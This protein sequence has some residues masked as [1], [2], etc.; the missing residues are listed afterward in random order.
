MTVTR[1]RAPRGTRRTTASATAWRRSPAGSTARRG[2]SRSGRDDRVA[3]SAAGSA[4]GSGVGAVRTRLAARARARAVRG[5]AGRRRARAA[6]RST[7]RAR[8]V[9]P[10]PSRARSSGSSASARSRSATASTSP[11]GTTK[12]ETPSVDD[13]AHAADVG[14]DDGLAGRLRLDHRDRRALVRRGERDDV[15]R[16]VDRAD[17]GPEPGEVAAV[18][19]SELA[20][21]RL[22]ARPQ[23]PVADE[24]QVGVDARRRGGARRRAAGRRRC[25]ISVMRPSQRRGSRSGGHAE[26]G[27]GAPP[28]L[29]ARSRAAARDRARAGS[30]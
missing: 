24:Q 19:D 1:A 21:E 17:V 11:G 15:A 6:A 27:D 7:A 12:P 9:R 13:V 4:R 22:E 25:L 8:R 16:R 14:R 30:R 28:P 2:R 5:R 26:L 10:A 23:R 18:A 20:G 3:P 29:R